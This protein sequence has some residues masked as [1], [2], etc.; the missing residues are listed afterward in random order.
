MHQLRDAVLNCLNDPNI[1]LWWPGLAPRLTSQFNSQLESYSTSQ[2][3]RATPPKRVE[4]THTSSGLLSLNIE[5]LPLPIIQ[6]LE[7]RGVTF[8]T[9]TEVL[10]Q[11]LDA[12]N[13]AL[14]IIEQT[15]SLALTLNALVKSVHILHVAEPGYDVSFSDPE[16]PFSIFLN[17]SKGLYADF[18]T[19]EAAIH[20]AM[21]L[22]L[23]LIERFLPIAATEELVHFSPW[24]RSKRPISGIMHALY[25]FQVIREWLDSIKNHSDETLKYATK[26]LEAI[27]DEIHQLQPQSYE[28]HLTVSG[29]LLLYRLLNSQ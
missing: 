15:P 24:K 13:R 18:R 4:Q 27:N 29:R 16:L 2:Y 23:S 11:S 14:K 22:Q 8:A 17:A 1:P 10:T 5:L 9:E 6:T 12:I 26:R 3:L 28:K 21:H 19:A 20:E 7:P 25:V